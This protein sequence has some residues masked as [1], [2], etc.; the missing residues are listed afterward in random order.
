MGVD[1][2]VDGLTTLSIC[3]HYSFMQ[4]AACLFQRTSVVR[5]D[6]FRLVYVGS[7]CD[8]WDSVTTATEMD[9]F[10]CIGVWGHYT[11]T[12]VIEN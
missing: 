1:L 12:G 6:D 11:V 2:A 8:G 10:V 3:F 7:A 5:R 4:H 9:K